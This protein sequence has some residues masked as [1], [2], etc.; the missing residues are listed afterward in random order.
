[1]VR[2]SMPRS[3]TKVR[4]G[5]DDGNHLLEAAKDFF[6]GHTRATFMLPVRL[7]SSVRTVTLMI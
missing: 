3:R 7:K 6:P 4:M 1:M 2:E 5:T